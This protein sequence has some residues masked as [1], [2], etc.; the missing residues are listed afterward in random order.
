MEHVRK[1]PAL[2]LPSSGYL[3]ASSASFTVSADA[4]S[5]NEIA[6]QAYRPVARSFS[7]LD[8]ARIDL[9]FHPKFLSLDHKG[10]TLILSEFVCFIGGSLE[11]V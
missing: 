7:D 8:V 11:L 4:I 6:E 2:I 1:W 3:I 9:I 10:I 5:Q